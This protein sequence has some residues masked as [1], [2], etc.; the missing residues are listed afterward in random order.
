MPGQGRGEP[1]PGKGRGEACPAGARLAVEDVRTDRSQGH[2]AA[3]R[4]LRRAVGAP[5]RAYRRR[6]HRL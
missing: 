5:V 2:K 4:A 6:A 1:C 3:K